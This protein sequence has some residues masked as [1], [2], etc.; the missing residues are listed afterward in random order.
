MT[1]RLLA[2]LALFALA[3]AAHAQ[4][5]V[6]FADAAVRAVQFVDKDEGWAVGDDG[7]VWHSIDGGAHWERQKTGSRASLRGVH[8]Q[9]PYTGWAVGRL[10]APNGVSA[11]VMLKTADGGLTWEEVGVN[12]LPGLH[13]VRFFDDKNGFVCG[14]GSDAFPT[15]MFHTADGGK[16]WRPVS[17]AR[18]PGWRAADFDAQGTG[19]VAGVWS[20]LAVVRG[21]ALAD[22]DLDPLG[23]RA[24]HAIKN[25]PFRWVAAGDGGLVMT[26]DDGRRWGA[27]NLGVPAAVAMSCDFRAVAAS[28]THVWVAGRPGS[29]VFH[30]PDGGK[31]WETQKT[32]LTTP[33]LGMHFLDATT[34]WAVGELGT[35]ARTTDGGRTWT[36][37]RTGGGRAA[38][39]FLN[40]HGRGAPL[41]L[42]ALVGAADG[43]LCAAVNVMSADPATAHPR[44]GA[45]AARFAQAVRLAGGAA[46]ETAWAFPLP[47]H[48][49]GL[50]PRELLATW[51][52]LHD[53]KANEQLL[54]QA[55]LAVRMWQPEVVVTDPAAADAGAAEVL[56]LHAAR[57]AFRQAADPACFPEQITALGLHP[58]APKKL[59]ALAGSDPAAAVKYDLTEF[60]R[61]LG[62]SARDAA[63]PAARVLGVNPVSQRS[64]KL[65]AHRQDGAEA[66]SKLTDGFG[67]ARGGVA[68]RAESGAKFDPVATEERKAA[69][70]KRRHLEGLAFADNLDLAG[71]DRAL[72]ALGAELPKLPDDIA[73]R[74]A[75]AVA[76][77]FA[78]TGKWAEAREVFA[79]LSMKYPGHPLAVDGYRWLLRYHAGTETRRRVEVQQKLA[80]GRVSF[81]PLG[82]GKV[83]QAGATG[84]SKTIVEEDVYRLHDPAMIVKWHQACLDME[85]K[86]TAFG[87]LYSRDPAAWLALLAARRHVGKH[88]EADAFLRE[89]FKGSDAATMP[90]GQDHWRDCLAAELWLADRTL[91]PTPPK[92][93]AGSAFTE[94]RPLLDGK[95]DDPCWQA[96]KVL[97]LT[98]TS[99]SNRPDDAAAFAAGYKTE[100]KFAH[101]GQYLYVAVSCA[102]PAGKAVAAVAKRDRDADMTGRDRVDIT[103]DLDRDYQTYYRFQVDQRG[104]LAED[105]WGDRTWNPKY[106]VAFVPG[107]AG[108]TCEFAIPLAELTGDRLGGR[109]WAVNVSRVVPGAGVQ[110]WSGPADAEPRPE[111]LGLL[112]FEGR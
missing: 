11:G 5:P 32:N 87:P 7:V 62:E 56:V 28:G 66:H 1:R 102:H 38:V 106:F 47:G 15:G 17:G 25:T 78:Q 52:R 94:T 43:Y 51:D 8:F 53:G 42:A 19:V 9:N 2:L 24:V 37:S 93:V 65:I 64:L 112:R 91:V 99:A 33:V 86:L 61:E 29:V 46:A 96:A 105:C 16:T 103:L 58:W 21:G 107:E 81:D 76:T 72:G 3:P 60:V 26:S 97:P 23:G 41:D 31:T 98:A 104:C 80:F 12:V 55:V 73:A 14:D 108:W 4:P 6:A 45:D 79:L 18:S 100:A 83:V 22:A 88:A 39:L 10:D 84:G 92:P 75:H 82:G 111:G 35:I 85:P 59:Y 70:Q 49:A 68:R 90:P 13:A 69:A 36:A 63:E 57:E 77:R 71:A 95:L 54:R 40:A 34:G 110:T 67:L 44:A 109:A 89:Y 50:P 30:S 48:A 20:R 101:D 74:T 27:V